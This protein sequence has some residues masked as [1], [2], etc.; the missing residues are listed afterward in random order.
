MAHL[1]DDDGVM[2]SI[3]W[4]FYYKV[5]VGLNTRLVFAASHYVEPKAREGPSEAVSNQRPVNTTSTIVIAGVSIQNDGQ[6]CVYNDIIGNGTVGSCFDNGTVNQN[7]YRHG[8]VL[9][10]VQQVMNAVNGYVYTKI[11]LNSTIVL[12]NYP[13]HVSFALPLFA[14]FWREDFKSSEISDHYGFEGLFRSRVAKTEGITSLFNYRIRESLPWDRCFEKEPGTVCFG[15]FQEQP[16]YFAGSNFFL[17]ENRCIKTNRCWSLIIG[18]VVFDNELG[19]VVYWDLYAMAD[20]IDENSGKFKNSILK[21]YA[22]PESRRLNNMNSSDT[23]SVPV[24][25]LTFHGSDKPQLCPFY[26]SLKETSNC[27]A[28][29]GY[30]QVDSVELEFDLLSQRDYWHVE[31]TSPTKFIGVDVSGNEDYA[32]ID[33]KK[34]NQLFFQHDYSLN[35]DAKLNRVSSTPEANLFGYV[36]GKLPIPVPT[37]RPPTFEP[38]PTSHHPHK[39]PSFTPTPGQGRTETVV[40]SP[41]PASLPT[42]REPANYNQDGGI[43]LLNTKVLLAAGLIV[44]FI[45]ALIFMRANRKRRR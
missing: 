8:F 42:R 37:V 43:S 14:S 25:Q 6:L 1:R 11:R 26:G 36:N 35:G 10:S 7:V 5:E 29:S 15:Q 45:F 38:S 2:G 33:L 19:E 17:S 40:S 12:K 30:F 34:S 21:F 23:E 3:D 18:Q 24:V 16:D 31:M 22:A 32:S 39:G 28:S 20:H 44:L 13:L 41:S 27:A 9:E 4:D